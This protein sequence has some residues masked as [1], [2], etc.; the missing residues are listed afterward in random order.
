[1]LTCGYTA[2]IRLISP[3]RGMLPAPKFI[4]FFY[5]VTQRPVQNVDGGVVIC[6]VAE[7]T[8]SA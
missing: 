3:H 1:M 4:E 5:V 2:R 8:L 6:V 7:A